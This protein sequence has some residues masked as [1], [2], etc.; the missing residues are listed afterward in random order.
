VNPYIVAAKKIHSGKNRNSC[1]AVLYSK[2]NVGAYSSMFKPRA[3]QDNYGYWLR[4]Q[5]NQFNWRLT[6][7][8]FAAAMHKAG[9]L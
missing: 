8:C 3:E 4:G 1:V 7:L 5:Q 2:G 6:A 9:D